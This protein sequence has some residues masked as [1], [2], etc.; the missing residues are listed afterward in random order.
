VLKSSRGDKSPEE[1]ERKERMEA[2]KYHSKAL[3]VLAAIRARVVTIE[4][5]CH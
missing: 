2:V 3:G 1:M 4:S 5:E